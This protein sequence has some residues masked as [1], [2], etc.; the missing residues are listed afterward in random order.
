LGNG[1]GGARS[2]LGVALGNNTQFA[3]PVDYDIDSMDLRTSQRA[4]LLAAIYGLRELDDFAISKS[5][6]ERR[7]G[8]KGDLETS[9]WIIASD[10]QYVVRGMTEWY[11]KWRVRIDFFW[12]IGLGST[13]A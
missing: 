11:P 3:I 5:H 8:W 1:Y 9:T 7:N 6:Y 12:V 4:E 2:G 10:S 13:I